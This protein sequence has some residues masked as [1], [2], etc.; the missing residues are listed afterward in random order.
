M[1]LPGAPKNAYAFIWWGG[2][3]G[4]LQKEDTTLLEVMKKLQEKWHIQYF[5][6]FYCIFFYMFWWRLYIDVVL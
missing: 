6:V 3:Q 4:E 2:T 1:D 5:Y